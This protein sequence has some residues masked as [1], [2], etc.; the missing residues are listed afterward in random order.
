MNKENEKEKGTN[1]KQKKGTSNNKKRSA[2]S[3]AVIVSVCISFLLI[4]SIIVFFSGSIMGIFGFEYE[5]LRTLILF[6]VATFVF[7][8][9]FEIAT[10]VLPN[11]LIKEKII[12]AK[13]AKWV[14]VI[15]DTIA[16]FTVMTILDDIMIGIEG[17]PLAFLV[18]SLLM[19]SPIK[20]STF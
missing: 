13:V 14:F 18:I 8:V 7:G 12:T 16:T 9:P 10:N 6:F 20:D 11:M 1:K 15:M 5:N 3:S 2:E 17:T 4:F 19:A